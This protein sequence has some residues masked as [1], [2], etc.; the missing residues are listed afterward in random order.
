M[1]SHFSAVCSMQCQV[2]LCAS[3]WLPGKLKKSFVLETY[4]CTFPR[5]LALSLVR[6]FCTRNL[7]VHVSK[8]PGCQPSAGLLYQKPTGAHFQDSWLLAQCGAFVQGGGGEGEGGYSKNKQN[9]TK[10]VRKNDGKLRETHVSFFFVVF[11]VSTP[12]NVSSI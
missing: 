9:L 12:V 1:K 7:Q 6:G 3:N 2:S 10:G 11:S 8:T 5:L 4:R